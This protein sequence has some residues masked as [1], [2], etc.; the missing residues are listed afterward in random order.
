MNRT[1]G[2][3]YPTAPGDTPFVLATVVNQ[4]SA[5]LD[6][7]IFAD[8]GSI[9]PPSVLFTNLNP[10]E[11]VAG[12]LFDWPVLRLSLGDPNDT[13]SPSIVA[14]FPDGLTI[15]MP[16]NRPALIAGQDYDSGDNVIFFFTEDPRSQ[17]GIGISVGVID[18][19]G[20][21]G[22]FTRADTFETIRLLLI[23]NGLMTP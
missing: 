3:F 11:E 23:V 5:V 21:T 16:F 8:D 13:F 20:Q 6:L 2:T 14:T 22:P 1:F 9:Q 19:A 17:T 18:G 7:R 12:T 10:D 15:Q 4:T